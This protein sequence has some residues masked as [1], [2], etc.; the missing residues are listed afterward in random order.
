[1]NDNGGG[2]GMIPFFPNPGQR[3]TTKRGKP[4]EHDL[5]LAQ[6]GTNIV[7]WTGA[8]SLLLA[9]ALI[10][11]PILGVSVALVVWVYVV[12]LAHK[13]TRRTRAEG[14]VIVSGIVGVVVCLWF[15]PQWV[16]AIWFLSRSEWR[17]IYKATFAAFSLVVVGL[18]G[19]NIWRFLYEVVDP[20]SP[21][22][23]GIRPPE[24][25]IL[26]PWSEVPSD[27]P[28]VVV[29]VVEKVVEVPRPVPTPS[30]GKTQV[31]P[32]LPPDPKRVWRN[33]DKMLHAPSNRLVRVSDLVTFIKNA[34]RLGPAFSVWKRRKRADGTEWDLDT[35]QDVIDVWA[36][37]GIVSKRE[38]GKKTRILVSDFTEAMGM[39]SSAFD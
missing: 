26:W 11:G 15:G 13:V 38:N 24:W 2:G 1:M 30:N 37:Y 25:G 12:A 35:W 8:F 27:E 21:G 31:V 6:T 33:D 29:Q 9:N 36:L 39:L 10:I 16:E 3:E 28:E 34:P 17:P 19:M 22:P 4:T 5:P 32:E 23:V 18:L 7:L 14:V 20:N